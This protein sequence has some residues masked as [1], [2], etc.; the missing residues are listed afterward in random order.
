M[1][2]DI[3][4]NCLDKV[5]ND[6]T[7]GKKPSVL[8]SDLCVFFKI[9]HQR[10]FEREDEN[11]RIRHCEGVVEIKADK[12]FRESATG[13]TRNEAKRKSFL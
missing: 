5:F 11:T 6:P 8:L 7:V 12:K 9:T 3:W 2:K 13:K 4:E 1:I 10:F